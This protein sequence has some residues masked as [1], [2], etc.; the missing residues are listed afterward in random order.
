M[1]LSAKKKK[2]TRQLDLAEAIAPALPRLAYTLH[3][4]A[5]ILGVSYISVYRLVERKKLKANTDLP[6][7]K[8]SS[9]REIENF[10]G[11]AA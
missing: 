9:L 5:K 4:T 2:S 1:A 10:L 7:R 3:E 6:G 11:K 8:L